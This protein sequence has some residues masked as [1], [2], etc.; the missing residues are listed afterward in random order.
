MQR[1]LNVEEV[2]TPGSYYSN[3]IQV[4]VVVRDLDET[5]KRLSYLGFGQFGP[6]ILPP[7][8]GLPIFNGKPP[9]GK[10][11]PRSGWIGDVELELL[12]TIEGTS[13]YTEFLERGDEGIHHI[14]F[15]VDDLDM[16]ITRLGKKGINPFVLGYWQGGGYAYFDIGAGNIVLEL[17]KR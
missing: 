13:P 14:A 17:M 6:Q 2:A 16:E 15:G 9:E 11:E 12:Q 4:A 8:K 7:M 1:G 3:L 10:V 5:I